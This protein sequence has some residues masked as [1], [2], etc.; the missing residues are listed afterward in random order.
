MK[1]RNARRNEYRQGYNRDYVRFK[2]HYGDDVRITSGP[3]CDGV[4][5][6][7][8]QQ[9]CD[10]P[11]GLSLR[12]VLALLPHLQAWAETYSLRLPENTKGAN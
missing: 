10:A 11:I 3:D 8:V 1:V 7:M 12:H 5:V 4:E 6:L 9:D 2:E